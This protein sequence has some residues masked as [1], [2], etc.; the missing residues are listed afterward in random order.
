MKA[1]PTLMD[2]VACVIGLVRDAVERPG[3]RKMAGSAKRTI[4]AATGR[5]RQHEA[6]KFLP[7]IA[8]QSLW[9]G[10]LPTEMQS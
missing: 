6:K 10:S 8:A 7:F 2:L 9:Q 3:Q 5:Q 4:A 1:L